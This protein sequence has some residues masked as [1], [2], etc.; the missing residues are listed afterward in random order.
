[1]EQ[2]VVAA[3]AEIARQ[4]AETEPTEQRPEQ[5]ESD[6]DQAENHQVCIGANYRRSRAGNAARQPGASP[7]LTL[8]SSPFM[9][10]G[11]L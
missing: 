5:A 8:P 6:Q 11:L 10:R 4:M 1:M 3:I 9:G 2:D 7:P